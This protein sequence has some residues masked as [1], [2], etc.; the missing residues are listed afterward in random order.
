MPPATTQDV[1]PGTG[2]YSAPIP[3]SAFL[4]SRTPTVVTDANVRESTIPNILAEANNAVGSNIYNNQAYASASEAD[5]KRQNDEYGARDAARLNQ[6]GQT[7][8]GISDY[9]NMSYGDIYKSVWSDMGAGQ[10]QQQAFAS[11]E[12]TLIDEMKRSSDASTQAQLTAIQSGYKDKEDLLKQEQEGTTAG[13]KSLLYSSGA[14][15]TGGASG[16][17]DAKAANDIRNLSSL[18]NQEKAAEGSVLKAQ[19]EQDFQL[20]GQKLGILK[21]IRKDKA[22]LAQKISDKIEAQN[23]EIRDRQ[24][25]VVDG[26]NTIALDAAKNGADR[27][28]IENIKA[29]KNE[30]DAIQMAG[31]FL[32]TATGTLGDYLQYSRETKANGLVPKDYQTYKD[33]QDAKDLKKDITKAYALQDAK[34]QSDTDFTASDKTQQKLEQQYRQVLSKEFSSRTGALGIENGK[35]NQANHLNS[36]A[37]QYFDP[38]TGDY[39]IPTAQYAEFAL[40][41]ANLISPGGNAAESD[42]TEIKSYTAAGNLKAAIKY[43]TG[44]PQNGNTQAIIKNLIDSVDRQAETAVRNREAALQNM[45]DQAPTDLEQTRINRLNKSTKMIGYEGEERVSKANVD[46]YV[47]AN[48][49]DAETIAKMYEVPGAK[50]KDI[51]DYLRA[52]G[53]LQ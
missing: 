31:G 32:Q 44:V 28:T 6:N 48:P 9:A 50:N 33:D 22:D 5:T 43:I 20:L 19:Q 49:T 10:A 26:I 29:T 17:L 12:M 53:K 39:N 3:E 30:N 21:D 36:L 23:K 38:K 11:P 47:K 15:R 51:E 46:N 40:G 18:S 34:N 27:K 16:A 52:N 41:L 25:K 42:R 7:D 8:T 35:V 24:Q 14:Y 37:M 2:G 45:R 4:G 1:R 13:L